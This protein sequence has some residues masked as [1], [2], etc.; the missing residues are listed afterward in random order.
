MIETVLITHVM[1]RYAPK[2]SSW[3]ATFHA[4]R[5]MPTYSKTWL[6]VLKG[7]Y[8]QPV[9][10]QDDEI[11]DGLLTLVVMHDMGISTVRMKIME[12]V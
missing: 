1:K 12:K 8:R 7:E 3:D 6:A 4:V 2:D 5:L 10:I 11:I 9:I